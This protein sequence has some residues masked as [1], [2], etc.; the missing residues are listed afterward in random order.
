MDKKIGE[1]VIILHGLMHIR[2]PD[3]GSL[4]RS[5]MSA[6]IPGR[7]KAD[8]KLRKFEDREF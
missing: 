5:Y 8:E 2:T 1:Y 3:H 7:E 4:W 6:Y